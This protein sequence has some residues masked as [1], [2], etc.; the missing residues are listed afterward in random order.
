MNR[1]QQYVPISMRSKD[2][3]TMKLEFYIQVY[4]FVYSIHPQLGKKRAID[5]TAKQAFIS[6]LE[7]RGAA[8]AKSEFMQYY[9]LAYLQKPQDHPTFKSIF[10][11]EW[12]GELKKRVIYFIEKLYPVGRNPLII[13]MY[14][15]F[16][17]KNMEKS[18]EFS[19]T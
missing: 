8:L 13:T 10:T 2:L 5:S 7:G 18:E 11:R 12:I 19:H 9:A 4:F 17:E 6:Y 1:F 15:K 16:I 14:D 3:Q